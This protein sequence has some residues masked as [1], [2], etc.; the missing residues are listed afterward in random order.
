MFNIVNNKYITLPRWSYSTYLWK[1]SWFQTFHNNI[2]IKLNQFSIYATTSALQINLLLIF[3][4]GMQPTFLF[5]FF[6][7]RWID[8]E[9]VLQ[10]EKSNC[11]FDKL[12]RT[13]CQ[14]LTWSI[15]FAQ[16]WIK[17]FNLPHP[18]KKRKKGD[19][20]ICL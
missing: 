6:F 7:Q 16:L 13:K 17:F 12:T 3:F 14:G 2:T 18:T 10:V 1:D 11:K 20:I 15:I 19:I 8:P 5:C 4:S 9:T